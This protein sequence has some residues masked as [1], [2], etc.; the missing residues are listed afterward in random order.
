M[1]VYIILKV[2]YIT[3]SILKNLSIIG[4]FYLRL[5]CEPFRPLLINVFT[6]QAYWQNVF[7]LKIY[8][9]A[10]QTYLAFTYPFVL[11][12]LMR[13]LLP[14]KDILVVFF[15]PIKLYLRRSYHDQLNPLIKLIIQY[16]LSLKWL[17]FQPPYILT[18]IIILR[19]LFSNSFFDSLVSGDLL[20]NRIPHVKTDPN[21]K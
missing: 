21:Q 4:I 20:Q 11:I 3:S 12:I 10:T 14:L 7:K 8:N 2:I 15:L 5:P 18:T 9:L 17:A 6:Q 1:L 16:I 19:K 13:L